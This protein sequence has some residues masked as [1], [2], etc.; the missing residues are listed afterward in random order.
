M[1]VEVG[2]PTAGVAVLVGAVR[3]AGAE[4][5]TTITVEPAATTIGTTPATGTAVAVRTTIT[6][7]PG[8]ITTGTPGRIRAPAEVVVDTT[9][10]TIRTRI[11]GIVVRRIVSVLV[12][13]TPRREVAVITVPVAKAEVTIGATEAVE[14]P[15]AGT[16][17]RPMTNAT[18]AAPEMTTIR[19]RRSG[20]QREQVAAV[21]PAVKGL[22]T[23]AV[24]GDGAAVASA[25]GTNPV[26]RWAR[27]AR[28]GRRAFP[29]VVAHRLGVP[30][31]WVDPVRRCRP[32]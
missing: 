6:A 13:I 25:V 32:I 28:W 14:A 26:I 16:M 5:E 19:R 10:G 21:A 29:A 24:A 9:S 15:A 30:V 11:T 2:T 3:T 23:V 7:H 17:T 31:V 20:A 4:E 22:I 8:T 1:A 27:H 18:A 12:R